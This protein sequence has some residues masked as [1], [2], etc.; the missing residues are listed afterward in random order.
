M[1]FKKI[2]DLCKKKSYVTIYNTPEGRFISDGSGLWPITNLPVFD[3]ETFCL[4]YDIPKGKIR[5]FVDS[6]L[7]KHIDVS[8]YADN[9]SACEIMNITLAYC[10]KL[11]I[12]V[13][14]DTGIKFIDS[15]YLAPLKDNDNMISLWERQ[16][17]NNLYFVLKSGML[18]AGIV[19]PYELINIEFVNE[20]EK[21][22][23]LCKV[24]LDNKN[25]IKAEEQSSIF[26]NE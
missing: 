5:F 17:G 4:T 10:G 16:T 8:D 13:I 12:P 7:P 11:L 26:D 23:T 25:S 3:E 20:V 21:L 22:A 2:I 9:E 19:T 6:K 18:F 24:A 1:I 14:T 15:R